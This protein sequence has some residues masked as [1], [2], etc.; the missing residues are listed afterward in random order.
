MIRQCHALIEDTCGQLRKKIS[1]TSKQDGCGLTGNT[2]QSKNKPCYH[3]RHGHW[4]NHIPDGLQFGSS[5]SPASFTQSIGN[6]FQRF[7]G[8]T[9]HQRHA[10]QSQCKRAGKDTIA[11]PHIVNE[12]GHTEKTKDNGGYPTQ[13]IRHHADKTDDPALRSVFIHIDTTHYSHR[14][15]KQGTAYH[16][17]E[18]ADDGRP[19]T[20]CRHAVLRCGS[21]KLPADNSY[22]FIYNKAE[23]GKEYPY[24]RQAQQTECTECN[25]LR[26]MFPIYHTHFTFLC[27]T[28]SFPGRYSFHRE[29]DQQ[30]DK[31][32]YYSQKE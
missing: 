28:L 3:I 14:K 7:F 15:G 32:Q 20:T 27:K 8:S 19:N 25:A 4:Q 9:D 6:S 1:G 23:N 18:C 26:K 17:I 13:I 10:E 2:S 5:Q 12:Q 11:K 24:H 16:Q 29:V 31:E 30:T 22:T 21:Q